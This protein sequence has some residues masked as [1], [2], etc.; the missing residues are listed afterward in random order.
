[1][2]VYVHK[3]ALNVFSKV[4]R[5]NQVFIPLFNVVMDFFKLY[6]TGAIIR[7]LE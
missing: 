7:S 2:C 4:Q 6:M 3:F 1:M 5:E